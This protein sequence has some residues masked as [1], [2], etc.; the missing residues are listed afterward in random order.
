M[1]GSEVGPVRQK[2]PAAVVLLLIWGSYWAALPWIECVRGWGPFG[3]ELAR[4]CTVGGGPVF[5]GLGWNLVAGAVYLVAA[6]WL[7][8]RRT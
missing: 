6:A 5:G 3:A 8:L 1:L 7:G 2:L 4:F